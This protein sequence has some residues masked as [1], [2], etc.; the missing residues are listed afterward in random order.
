MAVVLL[1]RLVVVMVHFRLP[2]HA[3]HDANAAPVSQGRG[4]LLLGR[5]LRGLLRGVGRPSLLWRLLQL[6]VDLKAARTL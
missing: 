1:R 3:P 2:L 4:G 5:S 6:V